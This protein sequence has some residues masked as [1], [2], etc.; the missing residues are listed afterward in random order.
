MHSNK[1]NRGFSVLYF[2]SVLM[3]VKELCMAKTSSR[4]L[5]D[6]LHSKFTR[7]HKSVLPTAT[8]NICNSVSWKHN[9]KSHFCTRCSVFINLG[10][11]GLLYFSPL[12]VW[13]Y[14]PEIPHKVTVRILDVHSWRGTGPKKNLNLVWKLCQSSLLFMQ[15]VFKRFHLLL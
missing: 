2:L 1:R 6:H 3:W 13:F 10:L 4:K 14:D 5:L 12:M 15:R 9:Q 11:G 7:L 8:E